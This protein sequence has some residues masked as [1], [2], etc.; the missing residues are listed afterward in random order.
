[1]GLYR[2]QEEAQ[3]RSDGYIYSTSSEI[4]GNRYFSRT[5][6]SRE[7]Y[8]HIRTQWRSRSR[9]RRWIEER[10]SI[11]LQEEALAPSVGVKGGDVRIHLARSGVIAKRDAKGRNRS[12]LPESREGAQ[13]R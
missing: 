13:G 3:L 1:M 2:I 7:W 5:V 10:R 12:H 4:R 8:C 11:A 6:R 9:R